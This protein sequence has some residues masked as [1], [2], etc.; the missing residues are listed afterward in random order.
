MWSEVRPHWPRYD[1]ELGMP[2]RARPRAHHGGD[3][4]GSGHGALPREVARE[5][6]RWARTR[7]LGPGSRLPAERDLA[8]R[9]GASRS[10]LREA[11]KILETRGLVEVRHGV[12]TFLVAPGNRGQLTIP[13]QVR[14][15]ASR[16][17][18][19]EI[20]LARRTIECAVTE[21]GA[22]L[23]DELDLAEMQSLLDEAARAAAV[24]DQPAYI[25]ADLRFHEVLG[26][27][28]HNPLLQEVQ[29]EITRS[30]AAVRGVAS[31]TQDA[32]QA[33]V[34]FHGG[35]LEAFRRG[36]ADEARAVML[37]HLVDAGERAMAALLDEQSWREHEQA[38]R[39]GPAAGTA[40]GAQSGG[41]Q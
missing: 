2:D 33:A 15:E 19:E 37:L 26:Q 39:A 34:G 36:D 14:L 6:E 10:V 21:V 7:R 23:R 3:S 41:Q 25:E 32:M 13:V 17:P 1:L 22:R 29:R 11:I 28:T 5:V 30:T 35:I 8:G 12:G 16:L 4:P 27:C 9:L 20:F 31:A 40:A 18:V 38:V 24:Q